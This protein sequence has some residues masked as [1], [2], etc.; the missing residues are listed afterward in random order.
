MSEQ[1]RHI[2]HTHACL[3]GKTWCGESTK[4]VP[5]FEQGLF[6]NIEHAAY[7]AL[8][9]TVY[10]VCD[11]CASRVIEALRL[12]CRSRAKSAR[13]QQDIRDEWREMTKGEPDLDPAQNT[14]Q[15]VLEANKAFQAKVRDQEIPGGFDD[16]A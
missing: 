10:T 5:I 4:T 13:K 16:P 2:W 15:W 9:F 8:N 1:V 14:P 12:D 3:K 7:N 6:Q 11:K